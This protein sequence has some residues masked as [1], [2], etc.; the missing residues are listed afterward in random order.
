MS[1]FYLLLV[2]AIELQY[3]K[4]MR[5]YKKNIKENEKSECKEW[6][7]SYHP[8]Q[9]MFQAMKQGETLPPFL[10]PFSTALQPALARG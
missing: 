7:F 5:N 4:N 2:L 6:I 8:A 1:N 3:K 10:V 9:R